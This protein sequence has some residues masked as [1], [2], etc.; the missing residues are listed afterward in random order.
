MDGEADF[1]GYSQR[2]DG[3]TLYAAVHGQTL[4]VAT[5]SPGAGA[6][7]ERAVLVASWLDSFL[8]LPAPLQ[9]A[10]FSASD[11]CEPVLVA[12]GGTAR[13]D[14]CGLAGEELPA[15]PAAMSAGTNGVLEGALDLRTWYGELPAT[16]YLAAVEYTPGAGG[17]LVRQTP[18][19]NGN[20]N[21]EREEFLAIPLAAMADGNLDGVYDRLDPR[22]DFVMA[23][24]RPNGAG[25][26]DIRWN[27]VPGRRYQVQYADSIAS[28]PWFDLGAPQTAPASAVTMSYTDASA[29]TQRFYRVKLV[30]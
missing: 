1:A 20:R 16:I 4:Y 11:P 8:N 9:K 24:I 26:F 22:L 15:F 27:C 13:W 3:L 19:G 28:G 25:G 17:V 6:M 2:A 7:N 18:P 10:G 12:S 30:P 29:G 14:V 21:L 5:E 23:S